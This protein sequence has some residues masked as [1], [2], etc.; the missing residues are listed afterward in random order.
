[1]RESSLPNSL[2][3]G[4]HCTS[5]VWHKIFKNVSGMSKKMEVNKILMFMI[6]VVIFHNYLLL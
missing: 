6:I 4:L 2:Y 5:N 3:V 1:M